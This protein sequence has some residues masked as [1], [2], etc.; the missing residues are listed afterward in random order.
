MVTKAVSEFF[1]KGGIADQAIRFNGLPSLEKEDLSFN[2]PGKEIQ[3]YERPQ[4]T[5]T[6]TVASIMMKE[7]VILTANTTTVSDLGEF[8][9]VVRI[10]QSLSELDQNTGFRVLHCEASQ[11][12]RVCKI[13]YSWALSTENRSWKRKVKRTNQ[14]CNECCFNL[15]NQ[16]MS[17]NQSSR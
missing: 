13:P 10:E 11:S 9:L 12:S 16:Q 17:L 7:I 15:Q 14:T 2:A 1:D 4:R 8:L 3:N 5:E 6:L